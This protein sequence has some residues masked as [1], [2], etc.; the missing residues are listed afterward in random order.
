MARKP[1]PV[2]LE[3]GNYRRRRLM[4]TIKLIAVVGGGLWMIPV[5][6][7]TS[8]EDGAEAVS[9]SDALLY[10]FGVWITL[11]VLSATLILRLRRDPESEDRD[12]SEQ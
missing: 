4:D 7:P 10:V 9:M 2:F 1:T 5:L 3:R 11:I 12:G 8:Y 6:W